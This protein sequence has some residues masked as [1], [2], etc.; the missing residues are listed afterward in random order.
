MSLLVVTSPVQYDHEPGE[1]R[2]RP[3]DVAGVWALVTAY[4]ALHRSR[5]LMRFQGPAQ[6]EDHRN[7]DRQQVRVEFFY[8]YPGPIAVKDE[9]WSLKFHS[10]WPWRRRDVPGTIPVGGGSIHQGPGYNRTYTIAF[11][12]QPRGTR[13]QLRVKAVLEPHGHCRY[14][15]VFEIP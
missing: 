2:H 9:R 14:K 3:R 12:A 15:H 4:I 13:V 5:P 11:P 8:A 10:V 7:P 6:P 1:D